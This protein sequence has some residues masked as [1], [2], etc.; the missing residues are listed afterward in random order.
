MRRTASARAAPVNKGRQMHRE[1]YSAE[2]VNDV[3]RACSRRSSSG[4]RAAALIGFLYHTAARV[5]ETLALEAKDLDLDTGRARLLNTKTRKVR[6]VAVSGEALALCRRWQD[7][8]EALGISGGRR[9]FFCTLAG[10]PVST[11]YVRGLFSRL[12]RR[13]GL[14]R[15]FHAHGLRGT[16]LVELDRAGVPIHV[17]RDIAGHRSLGTTNG[18]LRTDNPEDA[19]AAL[20]ARDAVRARGKKDKAEE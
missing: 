9:P 17:I 14:E 7:R 11:A 19:L 13:A 3:I 6:T 8:R 12:G 16:A 15:R 5:G 10:G 4:V 18:Y 1:L 20:E 2:E